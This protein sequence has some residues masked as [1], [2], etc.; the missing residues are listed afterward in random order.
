MVN[1]MSAIV[2]SLPT[3]I[4]LYII[5]CANNNI[6]S[7]QFCHSY[8]CMIQFVKFTFILAVCSKLIHLQCITT[9]IKCNR[10][11]VT[12]GIQ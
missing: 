9:G 11:N 7:L 3:I 2:K 8:I 10:R 5:M 1:Q 12:A 4:S 6:R